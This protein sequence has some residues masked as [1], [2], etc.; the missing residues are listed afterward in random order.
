MSISGFYYDKDNH[1]MPKDWKCYTVD[2]TMG[3]GHYWVYFDDIFS[4]TTCN[5]LY[6][7][8]IYFEYNQPDFI[9]ISYFE[10]ASGEE[11]NPYKR[12]SSPSFKG[13][14]GNGVYRAMYH[15]N[16]PIKSIGIMIMPEYYKDYL[17]NKYPREYK[18]P[19]SAI[20]NINGLRKFPELLFLFKQIKRY[21]GSGISARLYYESKV[22]EAL[23]LVVQKS[24]K[25]EK[26]DI[27]IN[28]TNEDL[29]R[30]QTV[31]SYINDHFGYNISLDDLS[32][33]A[34]MGKTKLKYTFKTVYGS[35]ITNYIIDR[36]MGHAEHLLSNTDL[37][38][39]Q[40][41][42]I[43]GYKK[44]SSFSKRFNLSTG[45]LPSTYRKL[46]QQTKRTY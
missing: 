32:K 14:V 36:K 7:K 41:S 6:Y 4:I 45:I 16:I 25:Y 22:A 12:I 43:L 39:Q 24:K 34:C 17:M 20:H 2:S 44:V 19:T 30:L 26:S 38:I 29:N 40:I 5:F 8:D 23:S 42:Q 15:K 35:T 1:D 31:T 18:D 10:S 3:K 33:I 9:S 11:L 21:E 28:I 13:H 27:K 37:S 46:S